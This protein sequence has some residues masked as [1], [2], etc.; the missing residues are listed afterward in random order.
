MKNRIE[1]KDATQGK[2][3]ILGSMSKCSNLNFVATTLS[4]MDW[5]SL[6]PNQA[7]YNRLEKLPSIAKHKRNV[8]INSIITHLFEIVYNMSECLFPDCRVI[9]KLCVIGVFV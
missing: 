8:H 4:S 5:M 3:K 2:M 9:S 6:A 1:Q 7:A